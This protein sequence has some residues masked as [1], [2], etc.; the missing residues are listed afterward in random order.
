MVAYKSVR[1]ELELRLKIRI[2]SNWNLS[3]T[4]QVCLEEFDEN[5]S[6]I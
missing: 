4:N 1:K 5:L 2:N 6:A 3:P